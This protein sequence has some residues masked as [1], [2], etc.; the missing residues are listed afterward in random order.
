MLG[1]R[2]CNAAIVA[3]PS[4]YA[5][6]VSLWC[7]PRVEGLLLCCLRRLCV[8]PA[9]SGES[10]PSN[11]LLF[12]RNGDWAATDM[13]GPPPGAGWSGA[14]GQEGWARTSV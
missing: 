10:E 8:R 6:S 1:K 7:P 9:L 4:A 2:P 5:F 12:P 11:S 3:Q 14:V 13:L